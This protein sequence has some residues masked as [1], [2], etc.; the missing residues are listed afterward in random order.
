MRCVIFAVSW[1]CIQGN[2]RMD[3]RNGLFGQFPFRVAAT[4]VLGNLLWLFVSAGIAGAAAARA[5]ET[6]MHR[7]TCLPVTKYEQSGGRFL[8]A[9]SIMRA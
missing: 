9:L 5:F 4:T 3:A 7:C 6:G 2:Y 1:N 8:A